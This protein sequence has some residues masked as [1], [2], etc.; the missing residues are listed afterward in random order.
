VKTRMMVGMRR[1]QN[2]LTAVVPGLAVRPGIPPV[3][4]ALPATDA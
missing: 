4:T 2:G 3:A 1:L